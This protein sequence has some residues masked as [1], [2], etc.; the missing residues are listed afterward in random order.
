MPPPPPPVVM[1][2]HRTPYDDAYYFFGARNPLDPNLAYSTLIVFSGL[3]VS[4]ADDC[5]ECS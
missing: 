3:V 1:D 5:S 2:N 4:D